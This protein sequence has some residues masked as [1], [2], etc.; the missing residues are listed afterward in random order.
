MCSTGDA[1]YLAAYMR[2]PRMDTM[3]A[4]HEDHD[5]PLWEEES[6]EVTLVNAKGGLFRFIVNPLGT[7]FDSRNGDP[8][9]NGTWKV[10]AQQYPEGWA[11]EAEIPFATMDGAPKRGADWRINFTRSRK[12]VTNERSLWAHPAVNGPDHAMGTIIFN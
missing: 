10:S 5:A 12:N 2:D 9:W 6:L 1:F 8:A 7:R 11:L 4:K 3:A